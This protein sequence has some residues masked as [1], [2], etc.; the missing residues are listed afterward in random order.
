ML[1]NYIDKIVSET[2]ALANKS[3]INVLQREEKTSGNVFG[4]VSSSACL[5]PGRTVGFVTNGRLEIF[6]FRFV[7][8]KIR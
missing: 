2:L 1:Y 4:F 6:D 7:H 3:Q 8:S 5:Q